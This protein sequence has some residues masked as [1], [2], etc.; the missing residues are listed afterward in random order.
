MAD[1]DKSL[2]PGEAESLDI[3]DESKIIEL[4]I[5]DADVFGEG[6]VDIEEMEDGSVLVGPTPPVLQEGEFYQ[7]LAEELEDQELAKI[8]NNCLGDV[9]G[10]KSSRKEWEQQ[11]RDGLHALRRTHATVCWRLRRYPSAVGGIGDAVSGAGLQGIA[12]VQRSRTHAGYRR[13]NPG[14]RTAGQSG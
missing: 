12:A 5:P 4:G 10:D 6:E 8:L 9:Q 11:Y 7:N 13:Q 1:V 14:F 3:E 2:Y